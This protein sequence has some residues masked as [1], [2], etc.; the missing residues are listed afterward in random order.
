MH[1]RGGLV[2]QPASVAQLGKSANFVAHHLFRD[3]P[4]GLQPIHEATHA[5]R[6]HRPVVRSSFHC[7]VVWART[8]GDDL[9]LSRPCA[10]I[11]AEDVTAR[12]SRTWRTFVL[13]TYGFLLV[14]CAT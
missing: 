12:L 4:G 2:L 9:R 3:K 13:P 7:S 1:R 11:S 10:T 14:T 6:A 8:K 5:L